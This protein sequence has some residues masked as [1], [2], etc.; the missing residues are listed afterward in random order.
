M[1]AP[2]SSRFD[3]LFIS[4]DQKG[5]EKL[6]Q[7]P[8]FV[9]RFV[10]D[11][12]A[13]H[14]KFVVTMMTPLI[15]EVIVDFYSDESFCVET[16]TY[17]EYGYGDEIQNEYKRIY[18]LELIKYIIVLSKGEREVVEKFL[19]ICHQA[20]HQ[21]QPNPLFPSLRQCKCKLCSECKDTV[22]KEDCLHQT[23]QKWYE[24]DVCE[25]K[26]CFTKNKDTIMQARRLNFLLSLP[27][28]L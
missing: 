15:K 19:D 27:C 20:T 25:C 6:F 9:S 18:A 13:N 26:Q 1:N 4:C 11:D 3:E 5:A 24:N 28:L 17:D 21:L 16:S 2:K 8:A 12:F 7:C 23:C 10:H 14:F 22:K